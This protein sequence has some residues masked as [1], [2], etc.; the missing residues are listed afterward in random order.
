MAVRTETIKGVAAQGPS[1]PAFHYVK[2][3]LRYLL[4]VAIGLVLFTPF[5]LA[6]LGTFKADS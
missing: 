2:I 1:S 3:I 4:L 6:A 5:I